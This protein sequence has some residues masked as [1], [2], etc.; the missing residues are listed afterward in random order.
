MVPVNSMIAMG[1]SA[2][3]GLAVPVALAWWLVKKQKARLTTIVI[4]AGVFIVFALLLEPVL[5]QL[6]LKGPKG[7]VILGNVWLYALYGGLAAGFFEETGRFLA[8]KFLL[9]KEPSKALPAIAY[10]TGHGGVEMMLIFGVSMISNIVLS[11]MINTGAAESLLAAAPANALE[12]V[13]TQ[14]EQLETS[15]AGT[16][17]LGLWERISA[18]VLQLGLSILVWTA[19]RKGGKWFWLFPVAIFLH[20]LVDACAVVISKSASMAFTEIVIFA[21]ALAVGAIGFLLARKLNQDT[22]PAAVSSRP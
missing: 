4:G 15:S 12:E 19:V 2:L 6:V 3:A 16:F 22:E 5:H 20:F 14:F 9:Q 21:M 7:S 1:I 10:G 11:V 8:M 13:Q 17:F 18:L